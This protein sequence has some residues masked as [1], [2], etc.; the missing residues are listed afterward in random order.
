MFILVFSMQFLLSLSVF[1]QQTD[2]TGGGM[3]LQEENIPKLRAA[4]MCEAVVNGSCERISVIFS[5]DK[6]QVF[7]YSFFEDISSSRTIYHRWYRK[8]ELATQVRLKLQPPRWATYSS[9]QL[10]ESDKG[11]WQVEIVDESGVIYGVLRFSVTD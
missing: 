2:S 7:C 1:S 4:Y 6:R 9:I 11:P 10:R 5:V 3:A 8:G